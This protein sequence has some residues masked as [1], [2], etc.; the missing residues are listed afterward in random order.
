[1]SFDPESLFTK[2]IDN[3]LELSWTE[4]NEHWGLCAPC[5]L[6]TVNE[7]TNKQ[8]VIYST[9]AWK[10]RLSRLELHGVFTPMNLVVFFDGDVYV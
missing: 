8:H 2:S 10:I 5:A 9:A 7:S 6:S 3:F 4:V 1:M